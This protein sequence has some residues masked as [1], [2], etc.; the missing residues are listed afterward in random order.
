MLFSGSMFTLLSLLSCETGKVRN[1]RCSGS[2]PVFAGAK[3]ML[4]LR[5]CR[6]ASKALH[7]RLARLLVHSRAHVLDAAARV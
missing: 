7:G 6:I 4:D 2:L 5:L 3:P 1:S